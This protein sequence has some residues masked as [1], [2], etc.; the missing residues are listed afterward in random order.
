MRQIRRM[1]YETALMIVAS[2]FALIGVFEIRLIY[3]NN[4]NSNLLVKIIMAIIGVILIVTLLFQ[5][6]IWEVTPET[7]LLSKSN[8]DFLIA[9]IVVVIIWVVL[10]VFLNFS[11]KF[12]SRST[13]QQKSTEESKT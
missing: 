3:N 11:L 1:R 2:L 9:S 5:T 4:R 7:N 10:L 8:T 13:S 12:L 6:F